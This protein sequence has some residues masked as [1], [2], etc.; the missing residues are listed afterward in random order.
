MP[1]TKYTMGSFENAGFMQYWF[2]LAATAA[3]ASNS[4]AAVLSASNNYSTIFAW[5]VPVMSGTTVTFD[6]DSGNTAITNNATTPA[7][8]TT[9]TDEFSALF[10]LDGF[11]SGGYVAGSPYSLDSASYGTFSGAAHTVFSSTQSGITASFTSRPGSSFA[12]AI[13][14]KA[15]SS[16]PTF[17]I[18]GNAGVAAA[19]VAYSGTASGSVTADGSGNYSIT[20]LA[21]GGYLLTPSL[22]SYSFTPTSLSET[23]VSS[24]ITGA[25]FT[26]AVSYT[27]AGNAGVPFATINITGAA[28]ASCTADVSGNYV[29]PLLAPGAYLVT[30][31]KPG[32][33]FSPSNASE[34]IVS[35]NITGV[36]FTATFTRTALLPPDGL[37]HALFTDGSANAYNVLL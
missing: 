7:F 21:P 37:G 11:G 28:T 13:N 12:L 33:A 27:I 19:V 18:S 16:S 34:T 25:D 36:N 24:N 10:A 31:T 6:V 22:T 3:S 30:P 35:A 1:G 14:F 9:G 15:G 32:S 17:S 8:T 5:S 29:T 2:C 26:A 23:I 20:G 4:V